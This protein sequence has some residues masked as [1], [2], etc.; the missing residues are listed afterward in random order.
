MITY[1]I[2]KIHFLCGFP[3]GRYYIGKHIHYGTLDT[4]KYAGSG[5]F[6]KAY[7]K[8][9]GKILGETYLKEII[10]INPSEDINS[11]REKELIG[12]LYISDPLC[13][14]MVAGGERIAI[15]TNNSAK[16][17]I[18]YDL[19]G[20]C[21]A[22]YNS[23]LEAAASVGLLDS[24]AISKCCITKSGSAKGFIWRFEGDLL[25]LNLDSIHSVPICQYDFKGNLIATYSSIKDA[26][27][28]N[29]FK[30]DSGIGAC[31]QHKRESAYGFIWRNF[32]DPVTL[33]KSN[34]KSKRKVSQYTMNDEYITTYNSIKEAADATE[35]KWQSIQRVC[36]GQRK[37]TNNYK[38]KYAD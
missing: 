34:Y 14:N 8:K 11:L 4:D 20:N 16:P 27:Q 26:A 35:S 25:D 21:I 23:Q 2:Y 29:N 33:K 38:W 18:Q 28:K 5:N 32:N 10:E 22:K 24:T 7:Y 12:N 19:K 6:C 37:S 13:M 30:D 17:V 36:S 9:Y 3:T 15:E 1:Y 31:C